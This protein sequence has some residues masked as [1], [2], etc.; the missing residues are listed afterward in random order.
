MGPT[1][2]KQDVQNI[3]NVCQNRILERV[4]TKQDLQ[5]VSDTVKSLLNINQQNQQLIR[6]AEYQR[7]QMLRRA[8]AL[9][10]RIIQLEQDIRSQRDM[11][12]KMSS[13]QAQQP[14]PIV[15]QAPSGEKQS[16]GNSADQYVY[17]PV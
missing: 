15:I 7:S 10:T 11:L 4:A 14:Q 3:I 5:M 13:V 1:V 9:E 2:S 16:L 8:I 12:S 17:R 6:Q